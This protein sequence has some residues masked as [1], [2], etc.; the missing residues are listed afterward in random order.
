MVSLN[1]DGRI[2]REDQGKYDAVA[3]REEKNAGG[4]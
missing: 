3:I 1:S 4:L 2:D